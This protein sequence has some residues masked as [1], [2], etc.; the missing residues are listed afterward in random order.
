MTIS[1][2][3]WARIGAVAFI[4]FAALVSA[5]SLR[6]GRQAPAPFAVPAAQDSAAAD[7]LVVELYHCQALG[8]AGASDPDCLRA[9]AENRRRF[10]A[11]G[12]LPEAKLPAPSMFAAASSAAD[13]A[14]AR[15]MD[16]R[17]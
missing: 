13:Q 4:A 1:A 17:P 6:T 8:Q 12:A 16:G 11:P 5:L 15:P 2:K 7:P 14:E 9:W 3:T 10:L